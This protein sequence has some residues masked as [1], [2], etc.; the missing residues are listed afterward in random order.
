MGKQRKYL[1][2]LYKWTHRRYLRRHTKYHRETHD[3]Q[4]PVDHFIERNRDRFNEGFNL[5]KQ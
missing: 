2:K 5:M 3:Y 1:H 4:F